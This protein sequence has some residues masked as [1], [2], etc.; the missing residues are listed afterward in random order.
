MLCKNEH[1]ENDRHDASYKIRKLPA[2]GYHSCEESDD[3]IIR[4]AETKGYGEQAMLVFISLDSLKPVVTMK[5][6]AN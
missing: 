2:K 5:M 4:L 6:G 1:L 3:N